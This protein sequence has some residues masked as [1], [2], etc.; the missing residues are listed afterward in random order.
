[1]NYRVGYKF[2]IMYE[3]TVIIYDVAGRDTAR[4]EAEKFILGRPIISELAPSDA[5]V[6]PGVRIAS[7]KETDIPHPNPKEET[8]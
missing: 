8:S 5:L 3:G 7:V 6:P 2:S 4:S 1:M